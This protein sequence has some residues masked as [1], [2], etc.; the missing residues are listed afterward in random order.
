MNVPIEA[1]LAWEQRAEA[2][3]AERAERSPVL[4]LLTRR[5]GEVPE[6][7]RSQIEALLITQ[8]ELLG[9]ALLDFTNLADLETW[10]M[11]RDP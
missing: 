10:L 1:F 7:V 2:Q 4:R 8:L 6:A 5:V 3:G 11:E 9:E